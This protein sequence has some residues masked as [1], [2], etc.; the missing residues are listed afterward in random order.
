MHNFLSYYLQ[1]LGMFSGL[2]DENQKTH[3]FFLLL[4]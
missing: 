1:V 2:V 3:F 4:Y